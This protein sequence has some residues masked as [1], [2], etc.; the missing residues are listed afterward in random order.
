MGT[1][2][3]T[4]TTRP[5]QDD[6]DRTSATTGPVVLSVK[7]AAEIFGVSP[8]AIRKRIER[9]Q[10]QGQKVH[11]QWRVV[12][13]QIPEPELFT[14]TSAT[15]T[16]RQHHDNT[17]RQ[18]RPDTTTSDVVSQSEAEH[19]AKMVA[20]LVEQIRALAETKGHLE[21]E[22]H[23]LQTQVSQLH[24]R[25]ELAEQRVDELLSITARALQEDAPTSPETAP[26]GSEE[27]QTGDAT[28]EGA[29]GQESWFTRAWEW[30]RRH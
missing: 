24:Q 27:G 23:L 22:N 4:D 12:L 2:D 5:R 20:D 26:G 11:G 19:F 16:T 1:T 13:D 30:L 14:T 25:A 8:G 15:G 9:G 10:L 3:E 29:S 21:A 7:D 18:L 17:T 28:L 6:Y